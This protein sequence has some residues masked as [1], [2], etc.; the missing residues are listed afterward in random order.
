MVEKYWKKYLTESRKPDKMSFAAEK[1]DNKINSES[2][3][4]STWQRKEDVI[5]SSSPLKKAELIL[6]NWTMDMKHTTH[7]QFKQT[8][9][10][11][12]DS[13]PV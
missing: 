12:N 4:K 2:T 7:S 10:N 9:T 13:L 5:K 3:E 6:E 8:E 11:A 1:A